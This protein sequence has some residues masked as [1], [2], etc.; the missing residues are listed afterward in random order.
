MPS[1]DCMNPLWPCAMTGAASC[2]S[3]VRG[4]G[5]IIHGSSGCFFYPATLLKTPLH[6]TNLIEEDIIFGAEKRLKRTVEELSSEYDLLAVIPACAPAVTGEDISEILSGYPVIVI[7]SPGFIGG[8]EEGYTAALRSLP[9]CIDEDRP[10]VNISGLDQIDPFCRGN[11]IE[12]E[13]VLSRANIPVAARFCLDNLSSISRPS[14]LTVSTDPDLAFQPGR[15]IGTALGLKNL[16]SS[17]TGLA[18]WCDDADI[19]PVLDEIRVAGEAIDRACD[20]YLRRF[21]PPATAIFGGF[22]YAHFAAELLSDYLDAEVTSIGCRN[23]IRSSRFR[24][25]EARE[26]AA[27]ARIL[28]RDKPELVIGSSFEERQ[29]QNAAF[30]PLTFPFRGMV[31]LAAHPI[32]GVQGALS[33]METVLNACMDLRRRDCRIDPH[34]SLQEFV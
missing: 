7:D 29:D 30:V 3:G 14:P 12:M 8:C 32:A 17:L 10:G 2:L 11:L 26:M 5:V 22:S 19:D 28:E 13:R 33:F 20:K 25:E 4:I 9:C 15:E 1:N 27:V 31:R 6:C 16:E 21:E 34:I 23:T 18:T 24:V